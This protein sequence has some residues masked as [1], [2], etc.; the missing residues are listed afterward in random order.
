MDA[1]PRRNPVVGL[2]LV[3][4]G[5]TVWSAMHPADYATW[6]FE[7]FIGAIGVAVL[8]VS[9]GRFRFSGFVYLVV[10]LHYV[11]LATGA[12]YTYAQV[13]LFNWLRDVLDLSRNHFDRVG[14]FAQGVTPALLTREVLLR[15]T[16]LGRGK[17]LACLSICVALAF[18]AFYEILEWIWVVLFYPDRGPEWLGMQ[19]DSWDAQADMLMALLGG[20]VAVLGFSGVH[21]KS[22]AAI[23]HPAETPKASP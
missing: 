10:A 3:A 19:G 11:I 5:V 13:P 17:W 21:D 1:R 6:F 7:L 12:K 20:L 2:L 14:H 15:T 22:I 9:S 8:A 16:G 23:Q 18:S 4:A